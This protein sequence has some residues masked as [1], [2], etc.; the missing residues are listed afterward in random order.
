MSSPSR[1]AGSGL[2][3]P[4]RKRA[5]AL[6]EK[7]ARRFH[8]IL[9]NIDRIERFTAALDFTAFCRNEETFYAV[10]HA[11]LIISEAARMLGSDGEALGPEQPWQAIRSLGNV[12]R[13]AYDGV[14]PNAIWQIVR[15]DLRSLRKSVERV[16]GSSE[17][18]GEP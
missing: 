11:L 14:D 13:H 12:L 2:G 3:R 1:S 16:L 10:L 18:N 17:A 9:D 7:H 5:C 6:S 15:D 4:L 8:D